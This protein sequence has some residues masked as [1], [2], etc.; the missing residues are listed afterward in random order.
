MNVKKRVLAAVA[1]VGML[2]SVA[3]YAEDV[4]LNYN[5]PD[6]I[7]GD[8]MLISEPVIEE[9]V[10]EETVMVNGATLPYVE[11]EDVDGITMIPLREVAEGLGYTVNWNDESWS[12]EVIKGASYATMAIGEDAYAFSRMAHRP[13]GKAPTLINDKTYVPVN[14]V[15]E[16]LGG[17][18]DEVEEGAYKIATLSMATVKGFTE[19][20]SIIVEDEARGE[21]IVHIADYTKIIAGDKEVKAEEIKEGMFVGVEYGMAMTMSIPPQTTAERIVLQNVVVEEIAE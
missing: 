5:V 12:I 19:E 2:A 20:G 10:V 15:T 4:V 18:A 16:V 1:A 14:F 9:P 11:V 8:V 13:L 7:Q 21:V 17:Y 3:A 6:E